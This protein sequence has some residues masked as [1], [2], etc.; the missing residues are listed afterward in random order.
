M[1]RS[2]RHRKGKLSYSVVVDGKTEVWYF[3]MMKKYE[4]LP[5][6]DIIPE[7][8]KRKKLREQFNTVVDKS[9]IYD[10][11]FWVIDL[12][13]ILKE[14]NEAPRG[15]MSIL[16]VLQQYIKKL[17][18]NFSGNVKVF[19]N[20]PCL[21]Y[22]FLLH[23]KETGQYFDN[24]DKVINELNSTEEL[25]DYEKKERYFKRKNKDIYFRLKPHQRYA[26]ENAV[27]QGT[28][29]FNAPDRSISEMYLALSDLF[30]Q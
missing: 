10:K 1:A 24:C 14:N 4:R 25:A 20:N 21:E 7:I 15:S 17:Q 19:I 27:K 3:Q 8:P 6:I 30:K 22:W 18:L 11:V 28:F 5:R 13:T 2:N 12:D 23:F 29:D 9:K 16:N 26:M